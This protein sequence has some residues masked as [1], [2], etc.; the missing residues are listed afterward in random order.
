MA[1]N[2]GLNRI[3]ELIVSLEKGG[4]STRCS[5]G[6]TTSGIS[7]NR[8]WSSEGRSDGGR[9]YDGRK[10]DGIEETDGRDASS[11]SLLETGTSNLYF[12]AEGS[13]D[14]SVGKPIVRRASSGLL[15][16]RPHKNKGRETSPERYRPGKPGAEDGGGSSSGQY[17]KPEG[18]N[19]LLAGV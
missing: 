2:T 13:S 10:T 16:R 17:L 14:L 9:W 4:A 19:L 7:S 18:G 6:G 8:S 15:K 12:F 11:L 1:S 5:L 3:I